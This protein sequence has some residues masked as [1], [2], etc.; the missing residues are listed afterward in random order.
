MYGLLR[1]SGLTGVLFFLAAGHGQTLY[2]PVPSH[3]TRLTCYGG[4][5]HFSDIQ[6]N[7]KGDFVV[8]RYGEPPNYGYI[9]TFDLVHNPYYCLKVEW[10]TRDDMDTTGSTP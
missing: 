9:I 2:I 4:D 10:S 3:P 5:H 8:E 1:F 7:H 6:L